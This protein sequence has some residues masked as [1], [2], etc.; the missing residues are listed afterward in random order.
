[1][2]TDEADPLDTIRT[3]LAGAAAGGTTPADAEALTDKAASLLA[4]HGLDRARLA[5]VTPEAD[6]LEDRLTDLD[7]PWATVHAY[8]LAHV[9]RAMRCE[10]IGI[11]RRGPGSRLHLFGHA[12]DL[13][14]TE[15]LFAS[16][17]AQM[18]RGL[19]SQQVPATAPGVRAWRRSWQLGWAAAATARIKT[20]EARAENAEAV[21]AGLAIML[22]DRVLTV[23]RRADAAYPRT[24]ATRETYTGTGYAL[25]HSP[26]HDAPF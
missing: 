20:A 23:R 6:P 3:L 8:L 24:R 13:E 9:A 16:L 1:M 12:S 10:A 15:I 4:Q 21:D 22:R 7:N 11:D 25:G 2:Q 26:G 19:A 5:A 18:T 14:R 17:R